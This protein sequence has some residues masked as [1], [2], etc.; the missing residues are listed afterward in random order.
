MWG[1]ER[2]IREGNV[3]IENEIGGAITPKLFKLQR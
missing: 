1:G 3:V 2:K